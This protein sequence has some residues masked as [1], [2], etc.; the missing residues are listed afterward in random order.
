MARR[1]VT[2]TGTVRTNSGSGYDYGYQNNSNGLWYDGWQNWD[3]PAV[4]EYPDTGGLGDGRGAGPL[5]TYV[6]DVVISDLIPPR[7]TA[8]SR[9]PEGGVVNNWVGSFEV[10]FSE[11][12]CRHGQYSTTGL[13]AYNGKT[14]LRSSSMTAGRSRC[15]SLVATWCRSTIV[16]TGLCLFALGS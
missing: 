4:A 13:H 11:N 14:Y 5:A 9:L 10:D 15:T 7:V 8:V 2:R 1:W 12:C 3:Q 6:M 16:G